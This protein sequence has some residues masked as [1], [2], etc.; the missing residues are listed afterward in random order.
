MH[1]LIIIYLLVAVRNLVLV[2]G[3][4]D[5]FTIVYISTSL[6]TAHVYTILTQV[7][8]YPLLFLDFVLFSYILHLVQSFS[9]FCTPCNLSISFYP[10]RFFYPFAPRAIFHSFAPRAIFSIS[11]HPVQFLSILC[12]LCH[13][14][15]SFAPCAIVYSFAP[16]AIVYSFAPCAIVYSFAPCA[17][18][19]WR[20]SRTILV[21]PFL[22]LIFM[23]I[24]LSYI[25]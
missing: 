7:Q 1:L 20:R 15:Y 3:F 12:T 17:T 16:C 10:V 11:L 24:L 2:L 23:F 21:N 14:L 13:F 19:S 18:L 9:I 5:F 25:L 8:H 22:V 4:L 6:C